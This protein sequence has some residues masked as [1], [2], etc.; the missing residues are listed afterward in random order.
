[1]VNL[2]MAEFN[3]AQEVLEHKYKAQIPQAESQLH[4]MYTSTL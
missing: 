1:M 2:N 3:T 4:L